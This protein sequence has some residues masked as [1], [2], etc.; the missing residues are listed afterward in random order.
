MATLFKRSAW[1][2]SRARINRRFL[3]QSSDG[4]VAAGGGCAIGY[5]RERDGLIWIGIKPSSNSSQHVNF[6]SSRWPNMAIAVRRSGTVYKYVLSSLRQDPTDTEHDRYAF[7]DLSGLSSDIIEGFEDSTRV[8]TVIFDKSRPGVS[9]SAL[10]YRDTTEQTNY[11][12]TTVRTGEVRFLT[13]AQGPLYIDGASNQITDLRATTSNRLRLVT[14]DA[15]TRYDN[16]HIAIRHDSTGETYSFDM[17]AARKVN[18]RT[19]ELTILPQTRSAMS[20]R[21]TASRSFTTM[22]LDDTTT[23][24][25]VGNL[26]FAP[27]YEELAVTDI[28][29]VTVDGIEQQ[30]GGA[31]DTWSF[32]RPRQSIITTGIAPPAT[33]TAVASYKANWVA[34]A[35]SGQTPIVQRFVT[36]AGVASA[37]SGAEIA[38]GYVNRHRY[39]TTI[40]IATIAPEAQIHLEIGDGVTIDATDLER[41]KVPDPASGELW[42]ADL[43]EISVDGA[44]LIYS[45]R[46]SRR[47]DESRYREL[48]TQVLKATEER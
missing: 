17:S 22:A 11:G 2:T 10:T 21:A 36:H 3:A 25:D 32:S 14:A 34:R 5:K 26:T 15:I 31:G 48:W 19:L 44:Y 23:G 40:I 13:S 47:A 6:S 41:L 39:P 35:S 29:S 42:R 27:D 24:V 16:L 30:L 20:H 33:A 7:R 1:S 45:G 43:I 28:V 18:D 9:Y 12:T 8:E 46:F 4:Y 38:A 37:P